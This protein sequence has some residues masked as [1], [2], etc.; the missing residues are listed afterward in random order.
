MPSRLPLGTRTSSKKSSAVSCALRPSFCRF[1]PFL[2][3]S[4]PSST[5]MSEVPWALACASGLVTATMMW[6]SPTMPL[7]MKVLLPLRTKW[8][9]SSLALVLMPW[10]SEPA[11]GSLMAMEQTL[12]PA[13]RSG[14][15]RCFS[16]SEP[17]LLM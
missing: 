13:T 6:V 4:M 17:Y 9:P 2:K 5:T 10:R 8:S 14:M 11:S 12:F 3:P 7:E 15:S 16:S 1:L